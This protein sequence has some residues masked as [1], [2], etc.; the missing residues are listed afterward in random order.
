MSPNTKHHVKPQHTTTSAQRTTAWIFLGAAVLLFAG[1]VVLAIGRSRITFTWTPQAVEAKSTIT[2]L[3]Q[4]ADGQIVGSFSETTVSVEKTFQ[5]STPV[6][7]KPATTTF[8]GKAR[9]KVTISNRHTKAQPLQAGTRLRSPDGKIFRTQ[10]RVDVPVGGSVTTLVI[11]DVAG[12]SGA[13]KKGTTFILP[14]LWPGL[15]DKINGVATENFT[16]ETQAT[17]DSPTP[18][19][20]ATEIANSEETLI[21]EAIAQAK[22][23]LQKNLTTGN[24]LRDD[25]IT[26]AIIRRE[27]PKAGDHATSY[28]LKL[29]IRVTSIVLDATEITNQAKLLLEPTIT[30]SY[31]LLTLDPVTFGFAVQSYDSK[32]KK[33]VIEMTARGKTVPTPSNPILLAATYAGKNIDQVKTLL[34]NIKGVSNV[35][36]QLSPFWAKN[37][38]SDTKHIQLEVIRA[39]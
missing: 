26:T 2:A 21:T 10:E 24:T 14:G 18:V 1:V 36:I 31:Q 3:S 13:E 7:E 39:E 23:E 37:I 16:G 29:S 33:A 34:G 19:L 15:Q 4:P 30:D 38:S 27:G 6:V 5:A 9:G 32:A 12:E 8:T 17:A 35:Q 22:P 20:T 11:A 25:L 28:K